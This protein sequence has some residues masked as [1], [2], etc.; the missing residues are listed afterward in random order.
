MVY[1]PI[2]I[3]ILPVFV[4]GI[5]MLGILAATGNAQESS[6]TGNTQE[7]NNTGTCHKAACFVENSPQKQES[8][9]TGT[10]QQESNNTGNT[11]ESSN[12]GS[13]EQQPRN[14]FTLNSPQK[15]ES[16]NTGTA[17]QE[18]N[19]TGTAQQESNNTGTAQ[20]E[21]VDDKTILDVHNRERAAVSVPALVW[22]DKL[23]ADAKDWADHLV[24]LNEGKLLD[25]AELVHS[26]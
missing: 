11:Q 4:A 16:N 20:Q 22:S 25:E 2:T 3:M 8:S 18:S 9:N 26:T 13:T 7:S 17:Q 6:N 21:S 24:K 1:K 19:N 10:A 12:T 15:Q 5:L 23:A 14:S